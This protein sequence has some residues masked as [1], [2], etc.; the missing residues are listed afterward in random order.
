MV[1]NIGIK[2][3]GG[4]TMQVTINSR[5]LNPSQQLKDKIEE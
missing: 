2:T 3:E 4:S 1:Y 5:N